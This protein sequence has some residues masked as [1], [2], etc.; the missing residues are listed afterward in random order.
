MGPKEAMT[1]P[2]K[3]ISSITFVALKVQGGY[4]RPRSGGRGGR[5]PES[6]EV[7]TTRPTGGTLL[8]M[9]K[10]YDQDPAYVSI[11]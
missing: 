7:V 6:L 5:R 8:I 4:T 3:Y 2:E 1:Y 10:M 9:P 11:S